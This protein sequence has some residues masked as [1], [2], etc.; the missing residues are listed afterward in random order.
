MLA[1]LTNDERRALFDLL[2]V[3][4]RSLASDTGEEA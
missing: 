2:G 4:K 3:L 1:G